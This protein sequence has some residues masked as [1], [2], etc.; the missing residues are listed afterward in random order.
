MRV[1]YVLSAFILA[2]TIFNFKILLVVSLRPLQ[3]LPSF[4]SINYGEYDVLR[5]YPVDVPVILKDCAGFDLAQHENGTLLFMLNE[6]YMSLP[7][8]QYGGVWLDLWYPA[9]TMI[10]FF[11]TDSAQIRINL[12]GFDNGYELRV[13]T[14]VQKVLILW[15]N[16]LQHF[17]LNGS[18]N[19]RDIRALGLGYL[20]NGSLE[21]AIL[22]SNGTVFLNSY[23]VPKGNDPN[24]DKGFYANTK[25]ANCI[26]NYVRVY[27]FD[28]TNITLSN[29]IKK[30]QSGTLKVAHPQLVWNAF[31]Y[32]P[33]PKLKRNGLLYGIDIPTPYLA[34]KNGKGE[35]LQR[36]YYNFLARKLYEIG[37]RIVRL[38]LSFDNNYT[39]SNNLIN[40]SVLLIYKEIVE[41]FSKF[42]ISVMLTLR[43]YNYNNTVSNMTLLKEFWSLIADQVKNY[44]VLYELFNEPDV[45]P[46]QI[47]QYLNI[48]ENLTKTIHFVDPDANV[49]IELG[50]WE[51]WQKSFYNLNWTPTSEPV[52]F[53]LHLYP[54][55]VNDSYRIN[56]WMVNYLLP[57]LERHPRKIVV[58]EYADPR[59][60]RW[61]I[62]NFMDM[63]REME[64]VFY[65]VE[66]ELSP[67]LAAEI[68]CCVLDDFGPDESNI[69]ASK[70]LGNTDYRI[71]LLSDSCSSTSLK[72]ELKAPYGLNATINIKLWFSQPFIVY[73]NNIEYKNWS[74]DALNTLKI[75]VIFNGLIELHINVI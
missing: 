66:N 68:A 28:L 58:S 8:R 62:N 17:V 25:I 73:V 20:G 4:G 32:G 48:C 15:N 41:E 54:S 55:Y 2:L 47:P 60:P 72:M 45:Q 52:M 19:V 35:T 71:L 23:K 75:S 39:I 57:Y 38:P 34:L 7:R 42:N 64:H 1:Y 50:E 31:P 26:T 24:N 22:Y 65:N 16:T 40:T 56:N 61:K 67:Y 33:Q 46:Y 74:Y 11:E 53:S 44:S 37:V 10:V 21:V 29:Y 6:S 13:K 3:I 9:N 18:Q 63:F 51:S 12:G 14:D 70:F 5:F 27:Y 69:V 36:A 49:V 59:I 43:E 30:S